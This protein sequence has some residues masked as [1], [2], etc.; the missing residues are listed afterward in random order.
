M[1][2]DAVDI[3]YSFAKLIGSPIG[4][5]GTV[6]DADIFR[7]GNPKSLSKAL[8]KATDAIEKRSKSVKFSADDSEAGGSKARL[9]VAIS[10]LRDIAKKMSQSTSPEFNDYHWEIVG[11]LISVITSLLEKTEDAA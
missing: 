2:F 9:D 8:A 10:R 7:G 4:A 1:S 3:E 5:R 6:H 11:C